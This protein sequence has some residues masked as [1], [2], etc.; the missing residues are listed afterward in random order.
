MGGCVALQQWWWR[1]WRFVAVVHAQTGTTRTGGAACLKQRIPAPSQH[2]Q[3]HH[4]HHA[5]VL[6]DMSKGW[7]DFGPVQ[8][9]GTP[10]RM[11]QLKELAGSKVNAYTFYVA[12]VRAAC[13]AAGAAC[14]AVSSVCHGPTSS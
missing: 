11:W 13:S 12:E 1:L 6:P 5:Q 14:R 9:D 8:V 3:Q 4:T 2:T 10:G 7:A